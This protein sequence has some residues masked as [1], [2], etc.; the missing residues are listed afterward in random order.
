MASGLRTASRHAKP[1]PVSEIARRARSSE[2]QLYQHPRLHHGRSVMLRN[3]RLAL[4]L[5]RLRE[6][7]RD[8]LGLLMCAF[9][10]ALL[11]LRKHLLREQVERRANILV[12]VVARLRDEHHLVDARV[13]E[14]AQPRANLIRRSYA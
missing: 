8:A 9:L 2:Q 3:L 1:V 11:E 14:L 4:A 12:L 6:N 10:L 7:R 5:H 13:L